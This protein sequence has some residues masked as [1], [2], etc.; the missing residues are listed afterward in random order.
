MRPSPHLAA[1][2][3]PVDH[4]SGNVAGI[5]ERV[6]VEERQVAV[7][8]RL[9]RAETIRDTDGPG[10]AAETRATDA[11]RPER[12]VRRPIRPIKAATYPKADIPLLEMELRTRN[13]R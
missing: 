7:L 9:D 2:D 3:P 11:S 5:F 12:V 1:H 10:W 6:A 4:Y 13:V 8:P